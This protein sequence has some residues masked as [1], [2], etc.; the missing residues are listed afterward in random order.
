[1]SIKSDKKDDIPDDG[2]YYSADKGPTF[3]VRFVQ[4]IVMAICY[5]HLL[6]LKTVFSITIVAMTS[7]NST[8][9]GSTSN[10]PTYDWTNQNIILSTA[11]WSGIPTN[12]AGGYIGKK[13]GPKWLIVSAMVVNS[14]AFMLIPLSAQYLGSMGVLACRFV[15]GLSMG[16]MI[17]LTAV[18]MGIWAPHEERSRLGFLVSAT[19][20]TFMQS[21]STISTGFISQSTLGWPWVCYIFG[22]AGIIVTTIYLFVAVQAPHVHPNITS[23][24]RTYLE[25]TLSS[26][27]EN[28]EPVPWAKILT[29]IHFW[30]IIVGHA[31]YYLFVMLLVTEMPTFL[32]KVMKYD[33]QSN[34]T[35]SAI[36]KIISTV[37]GIFISIISDYIPRHGLL[38]VLNTRRF[39]HLTWTLLMT[40]AVICTTY[41]PEQLRIWAVVLYCIVTIADESIS[42][43]GVSVNIYDLSPKYA[44]IITGISHSISQG[45][46]AF[47]PSL[48]DWV[49]TDLSDASQ[50]RTVFII[51][52]VIALSSAIFFAIF[53]SSQRQNWGTESEE[54]AR[55]EA[56]IKRK[57]S[58]FS[59]YS[60][61]A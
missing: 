17:P 34:G 1:M 44:G 29:S 18:V 52:S 41:I 57:G 36:P 33:L 58:I 12:L 8:T 31:G 20:V 26:T 30:A 4:I 47:A 15:E 24:E 35:V 55:I 48:V 59:I 3:G 50:W 28:D 14:V 53:A 37:S 32:A 25:K 56:V 23:A 21:G 38:S 22:T 43:T 60:L 42:I 54:D 5:G 49:C 16:I 27:F 7:T 2:I 13:Y 9:S 40:T 46:S 45:V 39:F 11:L 10:A 51:T 19:V 6:T 61:A